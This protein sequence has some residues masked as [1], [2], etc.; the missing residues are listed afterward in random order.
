VSSAYLITP[1]ILSCVQRLW[2]CLDPTVIPA[3]VKAQISMRIVPD[4]DL[5]SIID[6]LKVYLRTQFDALRTSNELQV[7]R[8]NRYF[9]V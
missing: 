3:T 7:R 1:A 5:D 4:Q 8:K 6:A 2:L 9:G